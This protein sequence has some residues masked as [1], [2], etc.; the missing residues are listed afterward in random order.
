MRITSIIKLQ[1]Q[2]EAGSFDSIT[3]EERSA[4]VLDVLK[5]CSRVEILC[6]V[7]LS[8]ALLAVSWELYQTIVTGRSLDV[9]PLMCSTPV[10]AIL[11]GLELS[12]RR[13]VREFYSSRYERA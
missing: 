5:K 10:L 9:V 8:V 7:S 11:L 3:P 2:L 13:K 6:V 12:A 1:R 4:Q